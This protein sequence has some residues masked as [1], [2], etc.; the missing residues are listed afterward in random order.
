V[1]R[2]QPFIRTSAAWSSCPCISDNASQRTGA[3]V[4][5]DSAQQKPQQ[6]KVLAAGLG[7]SADDGTRLPLDVKPGDTILFGGCAGQEGGVDDIGHLIMKE[8]DV[9]AIQ[10]RSL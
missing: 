6:G 10:E 2:G 7:K 8:D 4:I 1:N 3:I 5:S 9:L